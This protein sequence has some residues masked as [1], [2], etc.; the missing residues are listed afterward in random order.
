MSD[1]SHDLLKTLAPGTGIRDGLERI[2]RGRTGAL[3]VLGYDD[4][5][6]GLCDGGFEIDVAFAPT[7]LRRIRS[8][9]SRM[10]VPG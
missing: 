4:E 1:L 3:I 6:A 2:R 7:R 10:P 8:S 9:P 5:I